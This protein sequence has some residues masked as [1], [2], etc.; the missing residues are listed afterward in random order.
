MESEEKYIKQI[1]AI[2]DSNWQELFA[3][4]PDFEKTTDF[5]NWTKSE[6]VENGVVS[7]PHAI[8]SPIVSDFVSCLY[9]IDLVLS[10]DW[11]RWE[12]GHEI[13]NDPTTDFDIYD[14]LTLC[15]LITLIVRN[16]RYT[17]GYLLRCFEEGIVLKLLK[18][19]ERKVNTD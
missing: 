17:E 3:Y 11:M 2:S 10:F 13:L 7:M 16:D 4:I 6:P 18:G 5:G 15:R 9:K 8:S 12:E 1:S 14:K 19:L